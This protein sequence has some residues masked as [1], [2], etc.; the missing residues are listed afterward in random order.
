VFSS[1]GSF[2]RLPDTWKHIAVDIWEDKVFD[3]LLDEQV[4]DLQTVASMRNWHHSGFSVHDSVRIEQGDHEGMV[5]LVEYIARCPFSLARMITLTDEGK[6]LYRTGKSGVIRFPKTGDPQ[7]KAGIPRN[8][9][10][11]DPLD[12]IAE[13]TQHIPDKGEY[14][15]RYYGWYSNKKRGMRSAKQIEKAQSEGTLPAYQMKVK[16]TWAALIKCIYEVDP[17][18]CPKCGAQ[19]KIAEFVEYENT[20][21]IRTHLTRAGLWQDKAPRPPPPEPVPWVYEREVD[22]N[23]FENTCV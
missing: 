6:V 13:V 3:L 23:F 16:F 12:F 22:P 20:L 4:I 10:V 18:E 19:M 2:V 1:N 8:F 7:L 11:F 17:L 5:R 21:A 14:Q 15:I 9:Q